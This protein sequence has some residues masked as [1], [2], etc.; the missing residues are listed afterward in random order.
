MADADVRVVVTGLGAVS[1]AGVGVPPLWDALLAGRCCLRPFTAPTSGRPAVAGQIPDYA[2]PTSVPADFRARLNRPARF[3]LEAAIQAVAD[4]RIGFHQENAHLVAGLFGSAYA[5]ASGEAGLPFLTTGLAASAT[6]LNMAGP[7][8]SIAADGASGLIAIGQAY[9]MIR[10]ERVGV[11]VAGGAEAPLLPAVWAAYEAAG[12]LSPGATP[13]ALRPYDARRDGLVLGEGAAALVLERLDVARERGARIYA[14]VL[15]AAQ[16]TGPQGDSQGPTDVTI[17][18]RA[19]T[20]AIRRANRSPQEIDVCFGA[21]AGT[22]Q[23]DAR[24]VDILERAFGQRILDAYVTTVTPVIG[25]TI[26]AAGAFS[27]LAAA[28]TLAEQAVPPHATWAEA[29]PDCGLDFV[30]RAQRDHLHH[31]AV[32]AYGALGQNA[33]LVLAR[34][35]PLA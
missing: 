6:G 20:E 30:R 22:R 13:D 12:L 9:E 31:A 34:P 27:A 32:G 5:A 3:A 8:Y 23:G 29:D 33:A 11:A 17:A 24:E 25:H 18:R 1:A 35:E 10:A 15:G 28:L 26:G 21:G 4:A 19:L 2:G 16:T 14:E 7:V